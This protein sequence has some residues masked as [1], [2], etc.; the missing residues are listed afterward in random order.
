MSP[1]FYHTQSQIHPSASVM[2][3]ASQTG[4][5][6]AKISFSL[7]TR[8]M[9]TSHGGSADTYSGGTCGPDGDALGTDRRKSWANDQE[10]D[11]ALD[12]E[13][14]SGS[15]RREMGGRT[16]VSIRTQKRLSGDSSLLETDA[17]VMVRLVDPAS[18]ETFPVAE[19]LI[20]L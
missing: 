18:W 16:K 17:A 13:D 2:A 12:R 5:A 10:V 15:N 20:S 8:P 4:P 9:L 11:L 14:R 7:A 6:S 1:N 3:T 19:P